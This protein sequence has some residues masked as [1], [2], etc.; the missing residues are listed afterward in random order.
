MIRFKTIFRL[1]GILLGIETL[2]L[3]IS[4]GVSFC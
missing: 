1:V 2:M 4:S 3:A